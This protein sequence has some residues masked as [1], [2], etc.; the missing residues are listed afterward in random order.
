[1]RACQ[2]V[3]AR[4]LVVELDLIDN[5]GGFECLDDPGASR[6]RL[7]TSARKVSR[8]E[9]FATRRL[10]PVAGTEVYVHVIGA[11]FEV[12]VVMHADWRREWC[13]RGMEHREGCTTSAC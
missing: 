1:M 4:V 3:L 13:Q 5:A 8:D 2:K 9:I 11:P 12:D 6:Q 10:H 7:F